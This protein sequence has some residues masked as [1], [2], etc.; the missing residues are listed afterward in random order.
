M[1]DMG[2]DFRAWGDHKTKKRKANKAYS[3]NL[4]KEHGI[5]F[6]SY[7]NGVHLFVEGEIDFYPSTGKWIIRGT[8]VYKS[9]VYNLLKRYKNT[10]E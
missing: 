2:D 10:G 7:N 5:R 8:N 9:G 1:G 3:T 4:L 6:V